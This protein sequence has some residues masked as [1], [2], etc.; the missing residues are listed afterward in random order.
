M[1]TSRAA[2]RRYPSPLR[3]PGGKGKIANY[4][5]ILFIKN[6]LIGHEYAEVY[7]GGATV[8][9]ALLFEDFASHIHINDLD[10]A[11]HAFWSA[12]LDDC[13]ALCR[14]IRDRPVT[15]AEW[16]R[17]RAIQEAT[18]PAPLDLAFSTFFLNRTNRSGIISGGVIGGKKQKGH[19]KI[20]A[21]FNRPALIKRIEKIARHRSRI[22]LTSLDGADFIRNRVAE[23]P[24]NTFLYLDPPYYVKGESRLY[25]NYYEAE[26]HAEVA[27]A[28]QAVDRPW[29][30][31]YDQAPE[32]AAL[33]P[34]APLIEYGLNYTAAERYKGR[35]LMFFSDGL[36]KPDLPSPAGLTAVD[37]KRAR[38]AAA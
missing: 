10:P 34:D 25:T 23:L 6:D 13:E 29:L 4:M 27:E 16:H 17:Q 30:V 9:L 26:D 22:T 1:S 8:A 3:Y 21:R 14:R 36:Q 28:I 2:E 11:L 20:A 35:E 12:V 33:Y 18:D 15:M 5:K 7:A 38:L 19:W 32:I 31:S 37:V 24:L